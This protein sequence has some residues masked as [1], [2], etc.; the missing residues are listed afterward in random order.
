MHWSYVFLA[1]THWF[2]VIELLAIKLEGNT[3][4][5]W[6]GLQVGKNSSEKST[7]I[8]FHTEVIKVAQ[9]SEVIKIAEGPGLLSKIHV[10]NYGSWHMASDWLAALLPANQKAGLEIFVSYMDFNIEIP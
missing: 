7:W 10:K 9:K 4:C 1:L 8:L 2:V 6:F 5:I 3:V